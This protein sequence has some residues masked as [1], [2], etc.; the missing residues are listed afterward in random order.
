MNSFFRRHSIVVVFIVGLIQYSCNVGDIDFDNIED[1]VFTPEIVAPIGEVTYTV[2]ELIEEIND[3]NIEISDAKNLLLAVTY[4][5]TSVFKVPTELISIDEISQQKVMETGIVVLAS[6]TDVTETFQETLSLEYPAQNGEQIDSIIYSNGDLEII[7]DSQIAADVELE[8]KLVDFVHSDSRDTIT[9]N[10]SLPYNGSLPVSD[11][12]NTTLQ[13]YRTALSRIGG[14]NVFN[15]I[16][17]GTVNI[18]AG[19]SVNSSDY[20]FLTFNTSNTQFSSV[21]GYFDEKEITI[22]DQ[23][24]DIDFF[25]D[26]E[27]FGLEFKSPEIVLHID[28][29]FGLPIGISLAGISSSNSDGDFRMLT[30]LATEKPIKIKYPALSKFGQTS[31]SRITIS[32]DI[33]NLSDLLAISPNKITIPISAT[34]NYENASQESNFYT[35]QS[36]ITTALEVNMP[37]DVKLGGY[38]QTFQF[39]I[40]DVDFDEADSIKL[41]VRTV[42]DLPFSGSMNLYLLDADSVVIHEVPDN[43]ILQSPELGANGRTDQPKTQI[44]DVLLNSAGITALNNADKIALVLTVDSFESEDNRFVKIYSDYALTIKIGVIA[45]LNFTP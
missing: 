23:T 22:Q 21:I 42:N 26:I 27:P 5:D 35:D 45:Y 19:Q 12:Q 40:D 29:S 33:S 6:P 4:R 14:Q 24:I 17:N 7:V 20:I 3:P 8:I 13:D 16:V 11:T 32:N 9:F 41:R 18:K 44:A 30:G 43:L 2:K 38:K 15:V 31:S 28:N 34:T 39:D 37:L 25:N 36:Q 1:P 10:V